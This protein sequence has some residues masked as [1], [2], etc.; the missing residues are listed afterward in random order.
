MLRRQVISTAFRDR[1]SRGLFYDTSRARAKLCRDDS[2]SSPLVIVSLCFLSGCFADVQ[3]LP[4]AK[5]LPVFEE[6]PL[7]GPHVVGVALSGGGSRAAYFGAAG[8][9]ALASLKN[10]TDQLSLLENISYLSSV[11]GGS[12]ASSY[13]SILK[14]GKGVRVLK[15]DGELSSQYAI[16]S[17]CPRYDGL[18]HST[19]CGI[20]TALQSP[21]APFKSKS[22]ISG[23]TTG[24]IVFKWNDVSRPL[25]A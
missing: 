18:K 13:F 15:A 25:C 5:K 19:R 2:A 23:G 21:L 3:T 4:Q 9:Q 24:P 16:S 11:S 14:P 10:E 6:L 8:L 20:P 12:V 1:T 17:G 22:H 7:A